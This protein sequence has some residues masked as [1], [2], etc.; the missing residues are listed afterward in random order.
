MKHILLSLILAMVS[1][2]SFA[3]NKICVGEKVVVVFNENLKKLTIHDKETL[4][5]LQSSMLEGNSFGEIALSSDETNIWFQIGGMMYCR[6]IETGEITKEIPGTNAYKFEL[7]A[8][9]DYLI[10]YETYEDHSLIYVYDLNTA[11]A[12]SYA[13]VDF[14]NFLETAHYD[15]EKQQLHLLSRTFESK[16]EKPAKEPMFGLPESAEEIALHFRQD[17]KETHYF[18]YNI[19]NKSVLYDE[20]IEYSPD[21]ECN[22]EVIKDELYIITAMGTAK[23]KEDY[24]LEITSI[25]LMNLTDY[26][27][28]DSEFVGATPY[29]LYTRSFETGE[30]KEMYDDETNLILIEAAGIAM[31]ETD[32]YC[33]NEGVFYRFK[34]SEPMNADFD[35][36][37]D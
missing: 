35:M 22:F 32:Y 34:R 18:V 5:V 23:V 15:H 3:S 14:V 21:F 9:Q 31:T 20:K 25:I 33:V 13:K 24:S 36:P 10:H 11:E 27:I 8:A 19:A 6:S 17:Q 16:T 30:Y 29:F 1:F 26:A 28:L 4:E 12:V 7:S 37:L 2:G